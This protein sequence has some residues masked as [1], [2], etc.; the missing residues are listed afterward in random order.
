[1]SA[2]GTD[3]IMHRQPDGQLIRC[4][5]LDPMPLV[6]RDVHE[7][8]LLHLQRLVVALEPESRC[9]LQQDCDEIAMTCE[10]NDNS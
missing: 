1:M 4:G 9:P 5:P 8:A 2:M 6:G 7:I 10:L 3:L